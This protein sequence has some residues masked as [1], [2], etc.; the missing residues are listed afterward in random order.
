M[1]EWVNES[2]S[3]GQLVGWPSSPTQFL[4]VGLGLR[5]KIGTAH[6]PACPPGWGWP[7]GGDSP[8]GG[9]RIGELPGGSLGCVPRFCD[10]CE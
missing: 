8:G 4:F 10:V 1:D 3:Q 5:L 9:G 2:V 7:E 6:R